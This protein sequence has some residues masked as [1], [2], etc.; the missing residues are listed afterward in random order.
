MK[1]ISLF[2]SISILLFSACKNTKNQ[3][4][5]SNAHLFA[6]AWF[7]QSAEK[8][9]AYIQAFNIAKEKLIS[10]LSTSKSDKPNAVIVDIDETMLDNSPLEA[11]LIKHNLHL[12]E[13]LWDKWVQL[14]KAQALPG[15]LDFVNFAKEHNVEVFYIS[16]R[17]VKNFAFTLKNLK[18]Q[19]FPFA[20]SSHILLE[21]TTSDKTPRR[22]KVMAKHNVLLLIG[23]NLRD[24]N[25]IFKDRKDDFGKKTVSDN[26]Q[27]FGSKYI[28]LPNPMYGQWLK[29]YHIPHK[30]ISEKQLQENMKNALI[31]F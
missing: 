18:N 4:C 12:T 26:K 17:D 9:A 27:L 3:D 21:D 6:T 16:N 5:T 11:Y 28:I 25:E 14:A 13:K 24:F 29:A 2:L 19:G 20:D 10:Q 30:K 22:E 7:Q 1:K 8:Q 23:D 31:A 15:A